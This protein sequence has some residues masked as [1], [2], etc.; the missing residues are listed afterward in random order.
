MDQHNAWPANLAGW[1]RAMFNEEMIW[2][3]DGECP[4]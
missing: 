3:G 4:F 2:K 1:M